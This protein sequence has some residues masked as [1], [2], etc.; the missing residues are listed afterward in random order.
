FP[1]T[2]LFRS[3]LA[4]LTC[5]G[6]SGA[7]CAAA[8]TV[9]SASPGTR[10]TT[11]SCFRATPIECPQGQDH[12]P[13]SL[14]LY[15]RQK[16][17]NLDPRA[18]VSQGEARYSTPRGGFFSSGVTSTTRARPVIFTSGLQSAMHGFGFQ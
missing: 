7:D 6:K 5:A 9:M 1:Y 16:P 11:P 18:G 14:R 12:A 10:A 8:G 15:L 17:C 4:W 2:T 3:M 13:E